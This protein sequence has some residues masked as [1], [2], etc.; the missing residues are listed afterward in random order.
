MINA[1]LTALTATAAASAHLCAA[2]ISPLAHWALS[3]KRQYVAQ[4]LDRVVTPCDDDHHGDDV[5]KRAL[6][7]TMARDLSRYALRALKEL[8]A[9]RAL[10]ALYFVAT[11]DADAQCGE[12]EVWTQALD[13]WIGVKMSLFH[14]DTLKLAVA[15]TLQTLAHP[16]YRKKQSAMRCIA[17][18]AK[19]T[20]TAMLEML[21]VCPWDGNCLL[22]LEAI[23][24]AMAGQPEAAQRITSVGYVF[25]VTNANEADW[26]FGQDLLFVELHHDQ[27]L[28]PEKKMP[29]IW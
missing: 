20:P 7:A 12:A 8:D 17:Q 23:E 19:Q 24:V 1:L 9:P 27:V 11:H 18:L 3:D 15:R 22:L 2:Y 4:A 5:T 10:Q 28:S 21:R 29:L 14:T 25:R 6:A 26:L 13:E 16:S